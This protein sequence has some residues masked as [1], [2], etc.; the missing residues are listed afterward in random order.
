MEL[1]HK[2]S[3]LTNLKILGLD[4][5]DVKTLPAEMV[6]SLKQ[7]QE[8]SLY[9]GEKLERIPKSFT[10]CDVFPALILFYFTFC[11]SLVE[12]PEVDE[13]AL[14]NLRLLH[15]NGCN[16]LGTLPLSLKLLT[17]LREILI[18]NCGEIMEDSCRVNC[19]KSSIWRSLN[20]NL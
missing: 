12:F 10:S 18:L 20:I 2:I 5:M 11:R 19:E 1:P 6:Y 4:Y 8:F 7:L 14:P 17:S 16:S 3:A 9:K 13:H 15:F